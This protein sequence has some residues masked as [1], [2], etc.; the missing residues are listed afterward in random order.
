MMRRTVVVGVV[1][2]VTFL[3]LYVTFESL[4]WR[5]GAATVSW[6]ESLQNSRP[7]MAAVG[8]GV[9]LLLVLDIV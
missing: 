6:V 3:I 8:V 2:F 7:V 5:T 1:V 9:F 4:G